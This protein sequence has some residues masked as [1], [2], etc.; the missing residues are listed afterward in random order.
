MDGQGMRKVTKVISDSHTSVIFINQIREK[1]GMVFGNPEITPGGRALKFAASVRIEL[2]K[3][4]VIKDGAGNPIGSVVQAKIIK[5]KMAPPFKTAK[6]DV[7]FGKGITRSSSILEL[8]L[9]HGII[10]K[11]GAWYSYN[12][13]N[14]GQGREK[15]LEFLEANE[16]V[17]EEIQ[18]EILSREA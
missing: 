3:K 8:A 13:G 10:R 16:D 11:K 17:M 2:R 1:V 9:E 15:T 14:V 12:D 4:E 6:F 5:N 7:R 18:K